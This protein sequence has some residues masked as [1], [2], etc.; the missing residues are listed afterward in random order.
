M[1]LVKLY[2]YVLIL[3]HLLILY[4]LSSGYKWESGDNSH[5]NTDSS[6]VFY[7]TKYSLRGLS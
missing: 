2:Y 5:A 7:S 3:I 1:L 6:N 4:M